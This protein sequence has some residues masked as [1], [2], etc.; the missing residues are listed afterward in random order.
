[1][2]PRSKDSET[3]RRGLEADGDLASIAHYELL[4]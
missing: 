2:Q 1:M 4:G 3:E